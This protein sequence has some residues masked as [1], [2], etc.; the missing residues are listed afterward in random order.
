[1]V[2]SDETAGLRPPA[3]FPNATAS[4]FCILGISSRR[5]NLVCVHVFRQSDA[6]HA[7]WKTITILTIVVV[8]PARHR[9]ASKAGQSRRAAARP[10][11]VLRVGLVCQQ[12]HEVCLLR[13]D[14]V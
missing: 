2:S 13:G 7:P 4:T 10:Q 8:L 9:N 5:I 3:D 6:S 1:M 12:A 14:D 11:A